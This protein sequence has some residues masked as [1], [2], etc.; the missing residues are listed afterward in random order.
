MTEPPIDA[1]TVTATEADL[2]AAIKCAEWSPCTCIVAQ[3]LKRHFEGEIRNVDH[4]SAQIAKNHVILVYDLI[5]ATRLQ[6]KFDQAYPTSGAPDYQR[7]ARLRA[8]LPVSFKARLT[9]E[10]E[11]DPEPILGSK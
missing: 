11:D 9:N 10:I 6:R 2:D 8:A 4:I 7:I 3:A 5:G 1:E